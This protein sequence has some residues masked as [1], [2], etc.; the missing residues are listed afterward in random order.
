VIGGTVGRCCSGPALAESSAPSG[1]ARASPPR[2][3]PLPSALEAAL[4]DSF[5][6]IKSALPPL[7]SYQRLGNDRGAS[8]PRRSTR[9]ILILPDYTRRYANSHIHACTYP[10][11]STADAS[12]PLNLNER[13]ELDSA[14]PFALRSRTRLIGGSIDRNPHKN[15]S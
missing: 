14:R 11:I 8:A 9:A 2:P 5:D 7:I 15:S 10:R 3:V 12:V 6:R 13:N 1:R 4:V